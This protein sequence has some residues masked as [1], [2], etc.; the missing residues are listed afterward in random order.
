MLSQAQD[1]FLFLNTAQRCLPQIGRFLRLYGMDWQVQPAA[2]ESWQRHFN[3]PYTWAHEAARITLQIWRQDDQARRDL[4]WTVPA[5]SVSDGGPRLF[6]LSIEREIFV[7]L[8][9]DSV[10]GSIHAAI[11]RSL[12]EFL[13]EERLSTATRKPR[14]KKID[15]AMEILALRVC[16]H[17]SLDELVAILHQDRT[18]LFRDMKAAAALIG[19]RLPSR[20]RPRKK[21]A[22]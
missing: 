17:R 10:R 2:I 19:V 9:V 5:P 13:A 22:D 7:T 16:A 11:D 21:I 4:R 6:R 3:L 1:R 18:T 20:G 12:D 8:D 14:P 15:R